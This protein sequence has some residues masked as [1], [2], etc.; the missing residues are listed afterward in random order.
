MKLPNWIRKLTGGRPPV[1]RRRI[2]RRREEL[3]AELNVTRLETRRVLNGDGL[4][5]EL[6]V[7][8]GADA[9]DGHADAFH[10]Q[11]DQDQVHVSVNGERVNSVS[12][13]QVDTITIHGSTDDDSLVIDLGDGSMAQQT[14]R[15]DGGQGQDSVRI[16]TAGHIESLIHA[17]ESPGVV[18]TDLRSAAGGSE[19]QFEGIEDL[20]HDLSVDHLTVQLGNDADRVTLDQSD[21]AGVSQLQVWQSFD[22][23]ID[24]QSPLTMSFG[25]PNES[26]RIISD[27]DGETDADRV[28]V[29]G[30]SDSFAA[31]FVFQGDANDLIVFSGETN[32]GGGDVR[33][34]AG[35]V[36]LSSAIHTD[37]AEVEFVAT[38]EL[39]L[40]AT[41][42]VVNHGGTVELSGPSLE[43]DGSIEASAGF[44][45]LD[46]GGNGIA[47]VRGQI[48]VSSDQAGQQGGVVHVLGFHVGLL[49]QARIDASGSAGGGTVLI[50][51][52]YL[53]KG[54]VTNAYVTY[55]SHDSI[56]RADSHNN[57]R[58][59]KV[60]V[61]ADHTTRMHGT[62]SARGGGLGGD[63][64]LIETSGKVSLDVTAS[65]VNASAARGVAGTWL[66][67]PLDV[68]ISDGSTQNNIPNTGG[69]F[70]PNGN[71][72]NIGDDIINAALDA[73][74]NV[75]ITT[76]SGDAGDN[77]DDGDIQLNANADI[78]LSTAQTVTLK[79]I[80]AG[81]IDLRG[82]ITTATGTLNV[83]LVANDNS[84][85]QTDQKTAEGDVLV[86][87]VV[88]TGGGTFTASGVN[89]DNS[90][91]A[92]TTGDGLVTLN[93]T[94]N[95]KIGAAIDAGVG[96][97]GI[98]TTGGDINGGGT[99]TA[100]TLTLDA[101][102]GIGTATTFNTDVDSLDLTTGGSGNTGDIT[103]VEA[104][105]ASLTV[106]T[107]AT[108]QAIQ[109]TATTGDLTIGGATGDGNDNVT[110][111]TLAG[112]V[113]GGATVTANA[114]VINASGGIGIGTTFSADA[115]SYSLT[116]LGAGAL[117][118]ITLVDTGALNTSQITTLSSVA[119]V[120]TVS[121][122]ATTGDLTINSAIGNTTDNLT[123]TATAGNIVGGLTATAA[124]LTLDA[125]GGI[126]IGT[127]V[128]ANA[129]TYV[130]TTSGADAAGDIHL[131]DTNTLNTS[132]VTLTTAGTSQ[133][134][135]LTALTG[136]L[137]VGNAIGNSTDNLTLTAT[138]GN[139]V[140][141][142][143]A[144]AA[145]LTVSAGLGIGI[146]TTLNTDS[147]TLDL[148]SGGAAGAGDITV[149]EADAVDLSVAT[150]ATA[151]TV[152]VT[153]SSGDLTVGGAIGDANDNL[154]LI[155]SAG[156]LVGGVE[157]V[158]A[159][160]LTLNASGGIG[161]GTAVQANAT[162]YSLT[163]TGVANAGDIVLVDTGAF[164]TNQ[165][166]LL[167]TDAS[168]QLVSL[169]ATT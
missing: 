140:G 128:T 65:S 68:T 29:K 92:I 134:V 143:T 51:G 160:A 43:M 108:A 82:T 138:A 46:S 169:T 162:S 74:T 80:A 123:L 127:A 53:G 32:L 9:N 6:V 19:F 67:D 34:T 126:G 54:E 11:V 5:S 150:A 153:V 95:V 33:V 167:S 71:N 36:Q 147:E 130:L 4:A 157:T 104:D 85:T 97:V 148:S 166:T 8:A 17:I 28:D 1:R 14:I 72:A 141:G 44:V 64:G 12:A 145:T 151:Q 137:T 41:G 101:S 103:L 156:N 27:V 7:D 132:Q 146:G 22:A 20:S 35:R 120:Q 100:A 131:S 25:D 13:D 111:I 105:G 49:D 37:D 60:I 133:T 10:L 106:A 77:S 96:D 62:I 113:D 61:W 3:F 59:G 76:D 149:I 79:L 39:T 66:L 31:S 47:I 164:N 110:L 98:T 158:S 23:N 75:T 117:G 48:D 89:F 30:L 26:L 152:S 24:S 122:T 119:S 118:N 102:G 87:D 112:N 16:I 139:V 73:G 161:I 125:N 155:A 88:T 154:S 94:G 124:T 15:F 114:L 57:G 159:N 163:T 84:G 121:L 107:D 56:V 86:K 142:A 58:G 18:D 42:S 52:D 38:E 135:H 129:T 69:L 136:H 109:V 168:K 90:G 99:V 115:A 21:V 45:S 144:T 81:H 50:G 93:H 55:L 70:T 40:T 78:V 165:I 2:D 83:E 116:T 91:G 63:G